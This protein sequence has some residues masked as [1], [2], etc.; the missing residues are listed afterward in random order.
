MTTLVFPGQ[1]SQY[2]GMARDFYD[3]F[4]SAKNTFELVEDIT[5]IKVKKIVFENTDNLLNITK[6][7]QI[8]IYTASMAILEVFYE[9][10]KNTSIFDIKFVLGHSLGEYSALTAS[11]SIMIT[12]CARLLK[13]R[14]EL[15]QNAYPENKSGMA[16]VIGLNSQS[17][18]KIIEKNSLSIE[19]ANDNTPEQVVISGIIDNL[20]K[21]EEII[22]NNGAKKIVY[23]NVSAAFHSKIMKEAEEKMR[24]SISEINFY[25]PIY[26]VISNYSA[27]ASKDKSIIFESLSKQ[28][29]SRVKWVNSVKLL[30]SKKE[31]N[32]IE[33]G[34][35][36]TLTG[37]IKRISNKFNHFN[38]NTVDDIDILKNAI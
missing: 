21:S 4:E 35:G 37:I 32:I 26:N 17:L 5:K 23:L 9:V 38:I 10:F 30:E 34:P 11:K 16:A 12:D 13:I 22:I 36:K 31:K 3:N 1:G 14:G 33:I 25:N 18:E 15:M 29:S 2:V 28:M 7:T 19:I 6:Y 27:L 8:C 24:D 20:K